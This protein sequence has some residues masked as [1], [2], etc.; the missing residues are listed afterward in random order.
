M[1][2][3]SV[4]QDKINNYYWICSYWEVILLITCL[5]IMWMLK[6][7][8]IS[9]C[10][11]SLNHGYWSHTCSYEAIHKY[12]VFFFKCILVTWLKMWYHMFTYEIDFP[13]KLS[14]TALRRNSAKANSGAV[15]SVLFCFCCN[16]SV[17]FIWNSNKGWSFDIC[18]SFILHV[19]LVEILFK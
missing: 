3:I 12:Q 13:P 15:L 16:V 11:T 5:L 1:E 19:C 10:Y 14:W 2:V 18:N 7:F 8:Y 9:V 6:H 4:S 17:T